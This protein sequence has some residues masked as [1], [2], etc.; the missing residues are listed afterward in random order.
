MSRETLPDGEKVPALDIVSLQN[1]LPNIDVSMF[2]AN[3]TAFL[4]EDG[5]ATVE[6]CL[7]KM[8]PCDHTSRYRTYS[9][10]CNNL[11]FPHYGNAFTPL[12]HLIKPVYDDG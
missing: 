9:G 6:E 7:P 11:K 10:W 1:I 8:L 5:Q 3:Y 4:S 2:V 12:R